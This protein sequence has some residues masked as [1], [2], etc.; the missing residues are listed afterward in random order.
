MGYFLAGMILGLSLLL[1]VHTL[2]EKDALL[3]SAGQ[4]LVGELLRQ[5]MPR[6]WEQETG[7]RYSKRAEEADPAYRR[8]QENQSFY[9]EHEYL[10]W[11]GDETTGQKGEAVRQEPETM[12]LKGR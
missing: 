9:R 12:V 10:A 4:W 7:G 3:K 6:Q 2:D 1:G 8:L 5:A 11:Y